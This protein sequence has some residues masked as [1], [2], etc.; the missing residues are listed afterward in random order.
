M[1]MTAG[2]SRWILLGLAV[3]LLGAGGNR[4]ALVDAAKSGDRDAVRALLQK[5]VDVNV[6]E[7]D[8]S[9]A[10]LWA[11]YRDDAESADLLLRAGAKVNAANDLGATPLWAA[12]QNGSSAMVRRL[13]AAGADPNAALL[14][15]ETPVMVAARSGYPEIVEQLLA[16]GGN[17]NVHAARGQTALMWAAAEKHPEVVRVLLARGADFKARSESWSEVQAAP[18]HGILKYNQAVPHGNETA[19]LFA[20]RE[21]DLASAK[22]LV[23]AGADVNDADAWGVSATVLAA[24]SDF[25]EMVG[26]L[27]EKG[28]DPNMAAAGFTALHAAIMHRDEKMVAALLDHGADPNA[29]LRTWTP[30]RRTS[31]DFNFAPALVG[32]TPF[33]LAAR[34]TQPGVMRLL[35]QH[36]AD[37][38]FVLH[39]DY[40]AEARLQHRTEKTTALMAAT[41]MGGGTAWAQP[42]RAQRE[43]LTLEAVKV[44][45]DLG[46][47]VNAANTDGRTALDAVKTLGYESV[48]KFL[49]EKGARSDRPVQKRAPAE[50]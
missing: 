16:K 17:P 9:T 42:A 14:A 38:K 26:F 47:D 30:T 19:L 40:I 13:L 4:P 7:A 46:V 31:H 10:L 43:P 45:A 25:G 49:V 22:L 21:G 29:P 5:K 33:W 20:V 2:W 3:F 18:P 35:V 39:S 50:E 44:A 28:A 12:S 23:A 11:S 24:H 37:P 6:T 36:G 32:A 15:G 41:G 27:L 48:V 34:F 1:R 8:G